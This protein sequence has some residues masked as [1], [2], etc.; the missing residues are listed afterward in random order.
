MARWAGVRRK[1]FVN[2]GVLVVPKENICSEKV[3][4]KINRV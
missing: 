1:G 2:K 3:G 4:G